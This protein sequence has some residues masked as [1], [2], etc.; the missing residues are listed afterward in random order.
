LTDSFYIRVIFFNGLK[1]ISFLHLV[2][3]LLACFSMTCCSVQVNNAGILGV[4]IEDSDLIS[5]VILNRGVRKFS[6]HELVFVVKPNTK[7]L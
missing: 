7:E 3:F 2:N 5:T 6:F 4:V 1:G